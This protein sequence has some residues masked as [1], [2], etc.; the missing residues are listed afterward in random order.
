MFGGITGATT[1]GTTLTLVAPVLG[2]PASGTLTNCTGLPISTGVSGL[3]TGA[4]TALAINAGTAGSF[5]AWTKIEELTPSA[6][7]VATFSSLGSYTHL[8]IVY[9]M[10]ADDAVTGENLVMTFN[11]DTGANYDRQSFVANNATLSGSGVAAGTSMFITQVSGASAPAN[12]PSCGEI[13]I[14][15]YRGTT[16]YKVATCAQYHQTA[17]TAAGQQYRTQS[18]LWRSTVAITSITLTLASGN[19]VSGSKLTLYGLN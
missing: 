7:G 15:D 11:A 2:T 17:A 1:D 3:G 18:G 5:G 9:S 16:F 10:R 14:F 12:V 8:R 13:N 4:A 6:T 19:Y